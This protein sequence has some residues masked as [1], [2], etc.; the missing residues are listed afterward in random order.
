MLCFN[1]FIQSTLWSER[2]T[3][4]SECTD[5]SHCDGTPHKTTCDNN[6]CV[7]DTGFTLD[8][9]NCVCVAGEVD[10]GKCNPCQTNEFV[11]KDDKCEEC[12]PGKEPA[13]D[14][15]SCMDCKDDKISTNGICMACTDDTK[16]PNDDMT[17]CVGMLILILWELAILPKS[18]PSVT[19]IPYSL[20]L[21]QWEKVPSSQ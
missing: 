5:D 12:P 1:V 8:Q 19:K 10:N 4:L 17:K 6:E 16:V 11:N 21:E 20:V 15:E 18:L 3:F 7:C 14:R 13:V 9:G 2:P